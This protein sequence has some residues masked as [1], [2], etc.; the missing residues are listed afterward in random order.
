[1]SLEITDNLR[2]AS[3]TSSVSSFRSSE[4]QSS[5]HARNTYSLEEQ[6]ITLKALKD[7][8]LSDE[9][10]ILALPRRRPHS[11]R[12]LAFQ[13]VCTRSSFKM[14]DFS[15]LTTFQAK[16][17]YPELSEMAAIIQYERLTTFARTLVRQA[18]KER[19]L[20]QLYPTSNVG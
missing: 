20:A 15:K 10:A 11:Q 4:S 18:Q 3:P 17:I 5:N 12:P 2:P 7:D 14:T 9:K 13:L 16:C 19:L 1:M 8:D 6:V